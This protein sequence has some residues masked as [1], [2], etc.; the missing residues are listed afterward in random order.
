MGRARGKI[1]VVGW[2]VRTNEEEEEEEVGSIAADGSVAIE[3]ATTAGQR[4]RAEA[5]EGEPRGGCLNV[6]SSSRK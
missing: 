5:N 3:S 4:R 6:R 1:E 2:V